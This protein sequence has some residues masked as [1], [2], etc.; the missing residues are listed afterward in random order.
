MNAPRFNPEVTFGNLL[1]GL[2][3]IVTTIGLFYAMIGKVDANE[4]AIKN[5]SEQR[6]KEDVGLGDSIK[7]LIKDTRE[8]D[9]EIA[10]ASQRAVEDEKEAREKQITELTGALK[11]FA[12]DGRETDEKIV[13]QLKELNANQQWMRARME[14]RDLNREQEKSTSVK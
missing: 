12:R 8:R 4:A 1:T 9:K 3:M 11:E 13:E 7:E 14:A 10:E 2:V 5:E 6:I